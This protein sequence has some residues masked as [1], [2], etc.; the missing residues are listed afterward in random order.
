VTAH[1]RVDGEFVRSTTEEEARMSIG[2]RMRTALAA[3]LAVLVI[4]VG[5]TAQPASAVELPINLAGE[6]DSHLAALVNSDITFPATFNGAADVTAGTIAGTF[7]TEPGTLSFNALGIL[8]ATAETDLHFTG[9]VTGTVDL[10]TFEVEVSATF[11]IE[12]KSFNL[13][14]IPFLDPALTCETVSPTTAELSGTYD[15]A[16][17]IVLNGDYT[18]PAFQNCGGFNDLITLFT[19]GSGHTIEATLNNV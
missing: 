4:G 16:T 9:P 5:G 13:L 12:L 17:G 15:P 18:I 19:S 8:P 6:V 14:G 10:A 3:G 11:T 2:K 7:D 1:W